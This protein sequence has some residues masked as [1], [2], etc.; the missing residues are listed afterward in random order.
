MS[1]PTVSIHYR[2]LPDRE[3]LFE[4][5][6]LEETPEYVVT[7]LESAPLKSPV[8]AAGRVIL[9]PGAS[10][11]W[12]TYPDRWYDLG[13][14]HLEDGTYTGLYANILTP[15]R[16]QGRRW[17]T[18]DLCLDVWMGA[19]G[20]VA[21]LDEVEFAEAVER[22]WVDA[23]TAAAAREHAETLAHWA[24]EGD[25]PPPHVRD[26]SLARARA[27]LGELRGPT[28]PDR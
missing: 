8:S 28:G 1:V 21:V 22:G 12:F 11:V 9:E 7:L 13:L 2:R 4:Q 24:R 6:V 23:P 16:M 10:V 5:V 3:Q 14:F 26:W 20:A 15:V 27:R 25:W 19:D 18:T 17:E